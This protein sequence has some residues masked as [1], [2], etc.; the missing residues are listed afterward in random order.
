[1]I[2]IDTAAYIAENTDRLIGLGYTAEEIKALARH[3]V[4]TEAKWSAPA[5][6]AVCAR[7]NDLLQGTTLYFDFWDG[8]NLYA[9]DQKHRRCIVPGSWT[10]D[11]YIPRGVIRQ[12]T[13]GRR[14]LFSP[15]G[16]AGTGSVQVAFWGEEEHLVFEEFAGIGGAFAQAL[17]GPARRR[18]EQ[19]SLPAA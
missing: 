11:R 15:N 19:N 1:M 3:A 18:A 7:L 6:I 4:A 5:G 16:Q 17:G 9:W 12:R 2:T 13:K 8:G 10:S 14:Y